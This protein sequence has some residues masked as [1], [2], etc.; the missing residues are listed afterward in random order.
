MHC[1][2]ENYI[3]RRNGTDK[4]LQKYK[5]RKHIKQGRHRYTWFT[6]FGLRPWRNNQSFFYYI[7]QQTEEIQ[8]TIDP[9]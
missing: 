5:Q 6:Q 7:I 3:L 4:I 2:L 1:V 9:L 8:P